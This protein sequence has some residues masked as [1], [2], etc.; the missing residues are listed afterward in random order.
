MSLTYQPL[1]PDFAVAPQLQSADMQ[2]LAEQGFKSVIINR[3]DG[4][5]GPDQPRSDDVLQ[6][7]REAGLQARY[8]PVVSGAMTAADVA[9]FAALLHELPSPVLA[10]CRTGTRCANLFMAAQELGLDQGQG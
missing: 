8:Q 2:S 3:P 7:A 6:A 4:E 5:G 9:E 10:F 1:T